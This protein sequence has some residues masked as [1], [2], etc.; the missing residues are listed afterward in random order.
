MIFS[1]I[2]LVCFLNIFLCSFF[3]FELLFKSTAITKSV[4][5]EIVGI[6]GKGFNIPPSKSSL[7]FRVTGVKT[8]GIEIEA[9]MASFKDPF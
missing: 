5:S 6:K 3:I 4:N 2:P 1:F 7:P 9:L 8:V